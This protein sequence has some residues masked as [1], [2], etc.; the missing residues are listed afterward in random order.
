MIFR[1]WK[2]QHMDRVSEMNVCLSTPRSVGFLVYIDK[3]LNIK[4]QQTQEPC[5]DE[6]RLSQGFS[7]FP[8]AAR[9]WAISENWLHK[10]YT[11]LFD[12]ILICIYICKSMTMAGCFVW[13][14]GSAT[15]IISYLKQTWQVLPGWT[16]SGHGEI[17]FPPAA[18]VFFGASGARKQL[19]AEP[20]PHFHSLV[21]VAT[22]FTVR[23]REGALVQTRRKDRRTMT[24]GGESQCHKLSIWG[25]SANHSRIYG[26]I[27]DGWRWFT[28]WWYTYPSE[29]YD[30][31]SWDDYSKYMEKKCSKPPAS[32]VLVN[33]TLVTF[34][35]LNKPNS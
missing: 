16:P 10:G 34:S 29:K 30:F 32:L 3:F 27:V 5:R 26:N 24:K 4:Q 35:S 1:I 2:Q 9:T 22:Q 14:N 23:F 17:C 21:D 19:V 12:Y 11:V 13:K 18:F 8:V 15:S 28:G 33:T 31:V 6:W 7:P 20:D 25:W